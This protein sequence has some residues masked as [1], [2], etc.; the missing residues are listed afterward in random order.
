MGW[1]SSGEVTVGSNPDPNQTPCN[2][3]LQVELAPYNAE[4]DAY[5]VVFRDAAD[6]T[7]F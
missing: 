4:G 7:L 3:L 1:S 2:I 5:G 6:S